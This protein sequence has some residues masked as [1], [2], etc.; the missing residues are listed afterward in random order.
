MLTA[1]CIRTLNNYTDLKNSILNSK[2]SI[3]QGSSDYNVDAIMILKTVAIKEI[4]E[5][6]LNVAYHFNDLN[7]SFVLTF[8]PVGLFVSSFK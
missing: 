5:N 3:E 7:K 8:T 2:T 6:N 4:V 1:Q